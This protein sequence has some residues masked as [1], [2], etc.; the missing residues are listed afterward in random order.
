[1]GTCLEEVVGDLLGDGV[2][3]R[4]RHLVNQAEDVGVRPAALV[5]VVR[6]LQHLAQA[7]GP[8]VAVALAPPLDGGGLGR[9]R[10]S[11]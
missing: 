9:D 6:L 4:L 2:V 8:N 3:V 5:Q 11:N 7:L 10:E 1:M